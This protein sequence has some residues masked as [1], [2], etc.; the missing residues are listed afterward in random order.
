M[1][2]LYSNRNGTSTVRNSRSDRWHKSRLW[3]SQH[4]FGCMHCKHW[5]KR[6][7]RAS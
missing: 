7:P 1:A 3:D 4:N 5:A 6:I 2:E